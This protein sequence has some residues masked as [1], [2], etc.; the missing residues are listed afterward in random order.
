M[1]LILLKIFLVIVFYLK[2][3]LCLIDWVSL[4]EKAL[5]WAQQF[6]NHLQSIDCLD[7]HMKFKSDS[8]QMYEI[9]QFQ[10]YSP[11]MSLFENVLINYEKEA[12][13]KVLRFKF[14]RISLRI[15]IKEFPEIA[16]RFRECWIKI[17]FK[18]D[19]TKDGSFVEKLRITFA[20]LE[21]D[22]EIYPDMKGNVDDNTLKKMKAG[23]QNIEIILTKAFDYVIKKNYE[24]INDFLEN[25]EY[26][27]LDFGQFLKLVFQNYDEKNKILNIDSQWLREMAGDT[28]PMDK[29]TK[30]KSQ[31]KKQIK[32]EFEEKHTE[33]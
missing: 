6:H 12:S 26:N 16:L 9:T 5:G 3:Y 23:L 31:G 33:L 22:D 8:G 21:F 18:I 30:E 28:E 4:N 10:I 29:V 27:Q 2:E 11:E 25:K 19:K 7:L 20:K 14:N 17:L 1:K 32:K 13:K 24:R 15:T